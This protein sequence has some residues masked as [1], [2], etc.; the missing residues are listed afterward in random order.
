MRL[1]MGQETNLVLHINR[2]SSAS[3]TRPWFPSLKLNL[4]SLMLQA[5]VF[6]QLFSGSTINISKQGPKRILLIVK[7]SSNWIIAWDRQIQFLLFF[8]LTFRVE[9]SEVCHH[10]WHKTLASSQASFPH[11][12]KQLFHMVLALILTQHLD[13][14]NTDIIQ[15]S[16]SVASALFLPTVQRSPT[17]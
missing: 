8:L 5:V 15:A 9:T 1:K 3:P 2:Y 17:Q 4:S 10:F 7:N 16:V 12:F 11:C 14:L 13:K 6:P